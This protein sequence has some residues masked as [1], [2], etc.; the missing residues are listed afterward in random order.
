[1]EQWNTLALAVIGG[2]IACLNAVTAFFAFVSMLQS[3]QNTKIV[4]STNLQMT[5]LEKNTNSMKDALV[6]L[7]GDEALARGREEARVEGE[8]KAA[9]LAQGHTA[10]VASVALPSAS[11]EKV[12]DAAKQTVRSAETTVNT[13][14]GKKE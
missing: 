5:L 4:E 7:T 6:K 14:I 1:M 8:I 3:R 2:V 10:G 13:A 9:T 11:I 12:I